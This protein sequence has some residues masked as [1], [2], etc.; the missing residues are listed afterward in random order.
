VLHPLLSTTES[1]FDLARA[2][3]RAALR[4]DAKEG[5][6]RLRK[7]A[8]MGEACERAQGEQQINLHQKLIDISDKFMAGPKEG[9]DYQAVPEI[10]AELDDAR[11]ALFDAAA[12]VFKSLIDMRMTAHQSNSQSRSSFFDGLDVCFVLLF[13]IL[14]CNPS[15]Q[16]IREYDSLF[17]L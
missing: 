15:C 6:E 4:G 7:D 12:L 10:R 1:G 16:S 2:R 9:V 5:Q 14:A 8:R 17:H 3:P 11:K 13:K